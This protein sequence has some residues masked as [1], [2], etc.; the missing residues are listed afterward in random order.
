MSDRKATNKYY[1]PEWDPSQ[2]SLN[3]FTGQ[4]PLR[5]RA[6]KLGQG[7][8][9][10]RF[11]APYSFFCEAC[12]A[13]HALGVRW[14]AEKS[15][16]G[17]YYTTPIF[18]FGI[19]CKTC[20]AR[21]VI[22]T[23]P[24]NDDY[25][26]ISGGKRRTLPG[27]DGEEEAGTIIDV[28]DEAE[29]ETRMSDPMRALEHGLVDKGRAA[30][31]RPELQELLACQNRSSEDDY[32]ANAAL[33]RSFRKGRKRREEQAKVDAELLGRRGLNITLLP[34]RESDA[35]LARATRFRRGINS[36]S[37]NTSTAAAAT[38]ATAA[39]IGINV[40]SVHAAAA[41]KRSAQRRADSLAAAFGARDQGAAAA[42]AA[43]R[44]SSGEADHKRLKRGL[45]VAVPA[46]KATTRSR[47]NKAEPTTSAAAGKERKQGDVAVALCGEGGGAAREGE[48]RAAMR[49]ASSMAV[50]LVDYA[51]S[52]G[53]E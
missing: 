12:G 10:V 27:A 31:R 20:N 13:H 28:P 46:T 40:K 48:S 25:R 11:E 14:N 49:D 5:A 6:R 47:A 51:P 4:H 50:S 35:V 18:A 36:R 29:R 37:A 30:K 45:V 53:S 42:A 38:A 17:Q 26:I 24:K 43:A 2:G 22:E 1:P 19:K 15:R 16:T 41:A 34:E 9:I 7:I 23:D 39:T 21:I 52:S 33:R 44:S 32:A 3:R 8:L